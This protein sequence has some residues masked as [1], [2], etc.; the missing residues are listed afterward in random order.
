MVYQPEVSFKTPRQNLYVCAFDRKTLRRRWTHNFRHGCQTHKKF[1]IVE[2]GNFLSYEELWEAKLARETDK[3]KRWFQLE[4]TRI[5][6]KE[7]IDRLLLVIVLASLWMSQLGLRCIRS[8]HGFLK[9]ANAGFIVCFNWESLLFS[10]NWMAIR[11]LIMPYP[12]SAQGSNCFS[13][14]SGNESKSLIKSQFQVT[15]QL[16]VSKNT[17]H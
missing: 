12:E 2:D 16:K 10:N 6:T 1:R 4:T 8:G 3:K 17:P 9:R 5:K 15:G 7:R 13:V 11:R 14:R